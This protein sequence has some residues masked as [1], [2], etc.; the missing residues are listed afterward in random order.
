MFKACLLVLWAWSTVVLGPTAVGQGAQD[1][2]GA[3]DQAADKNVLQEIIITAARK[4]NEDV[5]SV[6]IAITALSA[7]DL[8]RC[9]VSSLTD[10][11]GLAPSLALHR[12]V[13]TVS[14]ASIFLR[15]FGSDSN[16][17]SIDPPIAIMVDGI[18]QP[19]FSGNLV[20]LFDVEA[21]EVERGPQG[22]LLG[23]N[24]STGECLCSTISVTLNSTPVGITE[25][26]IQPPICP[27][28]QPM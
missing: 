21:V 16:D 18:Y 3:A 10:L 23:K 6:P 19:T 11:S 22:T 17:P 4:R 2:P 7:A 5:Q 12:S 27:I 15:G 20:D 28:R 8:E 14:Q 24:A 25:A 1:S 9:G 13:A 26:N